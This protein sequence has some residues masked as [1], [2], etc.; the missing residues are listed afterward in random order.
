MEKNVKIKTNDI[1]YWHD[2]A[3]SEFTP[4]E[5]KK[6]AKQ[7]YVVERIS[8]EDAWIY[9]V[10]D[11]MHEVQVL[12]EELELVYPVM[13]A[14]S[15]YYAVYGD[16]ADGM[17]DPASDPVIHVNKDAAVIDLVDRY[18][19]FIKHARLVE[20][21]K[22]VADRIIDSSLETVLKNNGG[23]NLKLYQDSKLPLKKA[24]GILVDANVTSLV[25]SAASEDHRPMWCDYYITEVRPKG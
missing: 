22:I 23:A 9:D 15:G 19:R 3:I 6:L 14:V 20:R 8:E 18:V 16:S 13:Y 10:D 4:A 24:R 25:M 5:R 17:F 1:V 12:P 7:Q 11:P 21:G 2:P